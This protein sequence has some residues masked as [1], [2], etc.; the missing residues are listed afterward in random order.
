MPCEFS[1]E[2]ASRDIE[3]KVRPAVKFEITLS[4]RVLNNCLHWER[5]RAYQVQ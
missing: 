4:F 1:A 2:Q 5:L 3:L